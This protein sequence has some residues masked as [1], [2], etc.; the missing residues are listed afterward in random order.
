MRAVFFMVGLL[1]AGMLSATSPFTMNIV[2]NTLYQN[3]NSSPLA[4][5]SIAH[6]AELQGWLGAAP[7]NML[8]VADQQGGSVT[9]SGTAYSVAGY[10][11]SDY[12]LVEPNEYY[13]FNYTTANFVGQWQQP[14]LQQI[15]SVSNALQAYQSYIFL[16]PALIS[17]TLFILAFLRF[18]QGSFQFIILMFVAALLMWIAYSLAILPMQPISRASYSQINITSPSGNSIIQPYNAT[19]YQNPVPSAPQISLLGW[20]V[21]IYIVVCM[22]FALMGI[23]IN[24]LLANR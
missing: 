20:G 21:Y 14:Q 18:P 22:V 2:S 13:K 11:M 12:M 1:L 10:N 4:I 19:V 17:I 15:N 23:I 6:S 24:K 9:I 8:K 5:Y 3:T 7:S 16:I